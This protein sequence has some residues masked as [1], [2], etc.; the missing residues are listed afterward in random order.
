MPISELSTDIVYVLTVEPIFEALS[1]CAALHPDPDQSDDE[2]GVGMGMG[3]DDDDDA[4]VDADVEA[5]QA[6][7][8]TVGDEPELSEAG[9]VR[10]DFASDSRFRPY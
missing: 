9:R 7:A 1:Q 4:F 3:G 8:H 5:V 2:L 6:I 10:S